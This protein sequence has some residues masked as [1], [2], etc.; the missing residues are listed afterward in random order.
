MSQP[1]PQPAAKTDQT[2]WI[3]LS[4]L[5]H[6]ILALIGLYTVKDDERVRF[7]CA[8]ALALSAVF[9]LGMLALAI[10]GG[11]FITISLSLWQFFTIIDY[12]LV[13]A[14]YV[15]AIYM[16]YLVSQGK[17]PRIPILG[18]FAEKNLINLFK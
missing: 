13:L 6:W 17:N 2:Y 9:C 4:Y 11:I 12:L 10:L 16:V 15:Y 1:N 18:D 8:Q 7:Q 14:Y 3:Y 5:L